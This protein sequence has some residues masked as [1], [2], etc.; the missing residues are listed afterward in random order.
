M[1]TCTFDVC[2]ARR[3]GG[4]PLIFFSSTESR[5][6]SSCASP[7]KFVIITTDVGIAN[8][9]TTTFFSLRQV[10]LLGYAAAK[11]DLVSFVAAKRQQNVSASPF[12]FRLLCLSAFLA[13]NQQRTVL[14]WFAFFPS[15][16]LHS[17]S[18]ASSLASA[19][20]HA[21]VA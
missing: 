5:A 8:I 12:L 2:F 1:T 9:P 7:R 14:L 4:K 21:A 15:S 17:P 3:A 16:H 18:L 6:S 11:A 13:H 10:V 20:L 19:F